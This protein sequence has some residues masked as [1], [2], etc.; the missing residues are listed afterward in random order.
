MTPSIP[1]AREVVRDY[2]LATR[3][4]YYMLR[5]VKGLPFKALPATREAPAIR[6]EG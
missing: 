5:A 4:M 3:W 1:E 6:R 2:E